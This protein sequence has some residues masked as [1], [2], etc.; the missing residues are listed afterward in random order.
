MEKKIPRCVVLLY[1]LGKR[2]V[3]G[4]MTMFELSEAGSNLTRGDDLPLT[5]DDLGLVKEWYIAASQVKADG[6][7]S[8]LCMTMTPAPNHDNHMNQ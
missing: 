6:K 8:V 5:A 1:D 7:S 2:G 4:G 3:C